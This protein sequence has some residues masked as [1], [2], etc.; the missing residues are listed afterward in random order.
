MVSGYRQNGDRFE[1]EVSLGGGGGGGNFM[2]TQRV[3]TYN[4]SENIDGNYPG[5]IDIPI[6]DLVGGNTGWLGQFTNNPNGCWLYIKCNYH[7]GSGNPGASGQIGFAAYDQ[8]GQNYLGGTDVL[9]GSQRVYDSQQMTYLD[10]YIMDTPIT[11]LMSVGN[12]GD[13]MTNG[14][15]RITDYS[16]MFGNGDSIDGTIQMINLGTA[17]A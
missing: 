11:A 1:E 3:Y 2:P 16:N 17:K 12:Y 6:A 14:Y 10:N 15:L 13:G 5:Y 8:N 4:L 9:V 7:R